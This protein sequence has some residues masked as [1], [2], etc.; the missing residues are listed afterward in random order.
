MKWI[1][2]RERM[3]A[4]RDGTVLVCMPDHF[5]YNE[6]EP[7]PGATHDERVATGRYDGSR[8]WYEG[9]STGGDDPT[10]WMPLPAP[11]DDDA[12]NKPLT[13]AQLKSAPLRTWVWIEILIPEAFPGH[14]LR[15][16]SGYYRKSMDYTKGEAFCC[17]YPGMTFE[18]DYVDY[19]NTWTAARHA[20]E[21]SGHWF[22][23]EDFFVCTACGINS[24]TTFPFCPHCGARMDKKEDSKC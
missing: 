22:T 5:P 3:P 23:D 6:L 20:P 14:T 9:G 15:T 11:V 18:F 17:G 16:V 7:Y 10:H 8:W 13:V 4:E 24:E 12:A 21:R 2:C 1:S 19:G